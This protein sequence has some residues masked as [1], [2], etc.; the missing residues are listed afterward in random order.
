[1]EEVERQQRIHQ[2]EESKY[3]GGRAKVKGL[4]IVQEANM[5]TIVCLKEKKKKMCDLAR[6]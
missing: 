1:M 4:L 5:S 3:E 2:I 6:K